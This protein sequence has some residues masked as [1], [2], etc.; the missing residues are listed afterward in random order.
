MTQDDHNDLTEASRSAPSKKAAGGSV[1]DAIGAISNVTSAAVA[2]QNNI[3]KNS[4]VINHFY[5]V[6][7][8]G[9]GYFHGMGDIAGQEATAMQRG[10]DKANLGQKVASGIAG[11]IGTLIGQG[12]TSLTRNKAIA[13]EMSKI[14]YKTSNG[15]SGVKI[16]PRKVASSTWHEKNKSPGKAPVKPV[17]ERDPLKPDRVWIGHDPGSSSTDSPVLT[18]RLTDKNPLTDKVEPPKQVKMS[19]D[20]HVVG[21]T[22]AQVHAPPAQPEEIAPAEQENTSDKIPLLG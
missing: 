13:G 12:I 3:Y 4:K 7:N 14:N 20:T 1:G 10:M 2:E 11:P 15:N 17:E 6:A 22:T 16:D 9:T 19:D 21:T 18:K 8:G 5:N